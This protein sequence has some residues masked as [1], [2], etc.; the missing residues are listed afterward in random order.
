MEEEEPDIII[1]DIMMPEMDGLEMT[2]QLKTSSKPAIFLILL[3]A[4]ARM[5][6]SWKGLKKA[7]IHTFQ[8]HLTGGICRF[9]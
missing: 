3:T 6:K 4:K 8:N 5:S 2:R 7:L 9:V 1:S